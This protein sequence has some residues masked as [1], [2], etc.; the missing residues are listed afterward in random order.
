[1]KTSRIRKWLSALLATGFA[2]GS[3]AVASPVS[4]ASNTVVLGFSL[5]PLNL[6]ISG[7]AGAAIPQVLLNNVYEGL[8]RIE[9]DGKIVPGLA[10][11]YTQ[12][13]DGLTWTFKLRKAKFHDGRNLNT[14]DVTWSFN[15]V[16]DPNDKSVLPAQKAEFKSVASVAAKGSDSVVLTLKERNNNLLFSLTQRGGVIFKAGTTNLATTANGTGPY[17]FKEWNRGN[18]ITLTRND[19]YWG[20]KAKTETV[21][22]RY[23]LDATALSNAMLSGQLDVLTAVT[24]PRLLST[25]KANKKLRVY[26]GTTNCEVV[27]SMNNSKAP[28]NNKF[29]RQAVRSAIDKKALIKT[30]V[31]G[32]GTQIGSFVPPTDPWYEDLNG[33]FPY[34]LNKSKELLAKGGYPSGFNV[35]LDV[36]PVYYALD[37]QEFIAASLKQVGINVTLKPVAW[38]EWI[39]RVFTKA[40]YDMSIVCHIERNDM[41][42][43]ANPNYYFKYNSTEYQDLIKKAGNARTPTA[44]AGFLKKAARVLAED[45]PSDW[46]WLTGN[47]QVARKN[48]S[49]FPTNSVGDAYTV[50]N[51]VKG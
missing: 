30:A 49:G 4:A 29:V 36:P 34:D 23:I 1:M 21:V 48:V 35:Q 13:K 11:S 50:A 46:L 12:S 27:L 3:L 6:D 39:D 17:L 26:S 15:R 24:A 47:N 9:P 33:L 44:Q 8:L 28:F 14:S 2:F 43:Y 18:N 19:D 10:E 38:A 45:S 31:D 22:F 42:I 41:S 37:S 16:L 51:I 5:E 32:Y 25:F 7:T 40:N 20:Q